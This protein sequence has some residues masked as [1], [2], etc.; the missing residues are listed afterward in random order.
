MIW[1]SLTRSCQLEANQ[2]VDNYWIRANPNF[3]N[4]GFTDGINSAILRYDGAAEAEPTATTAPTSTNPLVETNLHP[5]V[6]MPVV[7]TTASH[8]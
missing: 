5:L 4:V 7:R 2:A 1:A 6:A 8:L 3:G